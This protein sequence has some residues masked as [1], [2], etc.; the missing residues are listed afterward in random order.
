MED[1]ARSDP[2]RVGRPELEL[3]PAGAGA[4]VIY[5]GGCGAHHKFDVGG[6]DVLNDTGSRRV[7]GEGG[8][9]VPTHEPNE[10]SKDFH[11]QADVTQFCIEFVTDVTAF[12][13]VGTV[14]LR[15]EGD[16]DFA[17][18]IRVVVRRSGLESSSVERTKGEIAQHE[19]SRVAEAV[20]DRVIEVSVADVLG[21]FGEAVAPVEALS[22]PVSDN[23]V[24]KVGFVNTT[25]C[26]DVVRQ[27]HVRVVRKGLAPI[28]D[29]FPPLDL[30]QDTR[31]T[32]RIGGLCRVGTPRITVREGDQEPSDVTEVACYRSRLDGLAQQRAARGG[33]GGMQCRCE[34]ASAER[35]SFQ[36]NGIVQ[37]HS[38]DEHEAVD[39]VATNRPKILGSF[40]GFSPTAVDNR[41][42]RT[43]KS[44]G[45]GWK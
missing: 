33:V 24:P 9:I 14:L 5:V 45:L 15:P 44:A 30:G 22:E 21:P 39:S 4:E 12:L 27:P 23:P 13:A 40:G 31:D 32:S 43:D 37:L 20:E 3:L 29:E 25:G 34:I 19:G 2:Y 10:T 42:K 36:Q 18:G 26:I 7:D 28:R 38:V 16:S 8:G 17:H 41:E 1:H 6:S 35:Y 11:S